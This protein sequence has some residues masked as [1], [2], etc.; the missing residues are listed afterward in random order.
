MTTDYRK[1]VNLLDT[2]FP[3][4]G[5]LAKREPLWVKQWQDKK[6]YEA[7][8]AHCAGRPKFVLHDGPPYANGDI[9]IGHAVNKILKDII[10]RSK[11]LTGF[12]APYVPGW[13]CHGLPIELAVEKLHGKAVLKSGEFQ[14]LCRRFA[15]EQIDKQRAAFIR[16]GVLGDWYQPYLTM[17]FET[18]ANIVR[19]LGQIRDQ[20]YL[21]RGEKPVHWCIDCGSALAEAEVEYEDKFSPAI[22]VGFRVVDAALAANLFGTEIANLHNAMAVIW[23]TTPWTM[24]ANQAVAIHPEL[25]YQ[26]VASPKGTFILA[27]DLVESTMARYQIDLADVTCLGQVAGKQLDQL[28]LRHPFYD[29]NVPIILGEHVSTEAGTGL[30]HTAPAHG[31][32]DFQVGLA[33][34]LPMDN[35]VDDDGCYKPTT[36]LFAGENIWVATPKILATLSEQGTL[37]HQTKISHSYPHCWRHK[38]PIIFR[39][40]AQWFIS[41]EKVSPLADGTLPTPLRSLANAAVADTDFFPAWG[42]ARLESMINNRPDW[43]VSRQR[44]WGVP[45][46]FFIHKQTGELHP[47]SAELLEIVAQRIEKNGIEAWFMLDINEL[48]IPEEAPLYRK[49]TDTLDVWFDSGSTHFSVLKQRPELQWPADLYLEGS[50]QHRGWFQ[51]SLLTGCASMGKAPYKQLLTHGFVVDGKGHKMSKSVGNVIA[52]QKINDTLGADILRLWTAQTDSSGEMAISDEILKR[53]SES[54]RRLRNTLRF[55]LANLTDFN[56]ATDAIAT[57]NLLELDRYA[58]LLASQLQQKVAEKGGLYDKYAFHQAMQAILSYCSEDMGA[59]YLDIIKDRLYTT[60]AQSLARRSAQTALY[61]ITR[62]LLLLLSP[63]L[64]FTADEAWQVLVNDTE[65]STLFHTHQALPNIENATELETRWLALRALRDLANK[66]IE[67]LRSA[68]KIGSALQAVLHITADAPTHAHLSR[69]GDDAKFLFIVSAVHVQLGSSNR[70]QVSVAEGDKCERCWHYAPL[71]AD[72]NHPTLCARCV[73]NID[74]DGETRLA[75]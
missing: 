14:A 18:E 59:F 6:R 53:T 62:S 71:G 34:G 28:A 35:P 7:L 23:T 54:Y 4:R 65:D 51:S 38:T 16:L 39:S 10:V 61:H 41:M 63:V 52:P 20:G 30:V 17:N 55:L 56:P 27:A 50:D 66:E 9:H 31:I 8:R 67:G 72:E 1:T 60:Q 21:H 73:S 24:P 29:K 70:I 11:T 13:D 57:E 2:P 32:E 40:T 49:L 33:Y 47:N 22:D 42:R 5:D 69:L 46:T 37:V 15:H 25:Q 19:L 12:D 48:L 44:N 75:V 36:P 3:M 68:E 26:L 45:M 58:L 64:C 74:G 43:C